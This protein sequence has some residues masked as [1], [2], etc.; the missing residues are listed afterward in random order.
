MNYDVEVHGVREVSLLGAAD[1]DYWHKRLATEIL[2][3]TRRA[4]DG[5]AEMVVCATDARF[6]G[7]KF[8]ELSIGVFLAR[9]EG[10]STRDGLFLLRAYNS[11]RCFAFVE[12]VRF[13]TPYYPGRIEVACGPP[14]TMRLV[15]EGSELLRALM[16]DDA[17]ASARVP[18]RIVEDVWEGPILLPRND[19]R[20]SPCSRVFFAR[21]AGL[22]HV[23]PFDPAGD[24]FV[25]TKESEITA[26]KALRQSQFEPD[27]WTLR[28]S[29][30]HGKSNT[31]RKTEGVGL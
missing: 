17:D 31:V 22:T 10:E 3:P 24:R 7:V 14:A 11:V 23:Y 18:E 1:Y 6:M 13:H 20:P 4:G 27:H 25:L 29:A 19:P 2:H 30:T 15:V 26:L 21:L 9:N 28:P 12:R 16:S 5:R 8:R